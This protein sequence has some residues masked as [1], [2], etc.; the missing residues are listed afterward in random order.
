MT[1]YYHVIKRQDQ[2]HLHAG[3][4]IASLMA[5]AEQ[6][7]VIKAARSLA[8]HDG[9]RVVVHKDYPEETATGAD[10]GSQVV[11]RLGE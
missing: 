1:R 11:A 4:A 2:W 7:N 8:R 5:D 9:A 10:R 3:N 6:A